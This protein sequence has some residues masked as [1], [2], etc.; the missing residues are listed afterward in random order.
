VLADI[1]TDTFCVDPAHVRRLVTPRTKALLPVHFGGQACRIEEIVAIGD[2]AGIP[3][4]E[5]AAHSF[6]ARV[7]GQQLGR[8]GRATTFSFYAT[9]NLTS[10]E[11]AVHHDAALAHVARAATH[12]ATA[13]RY[14]DGVQGLRVEFRAVQLATCTRRWASLEDR[15]LARK[16]PWRT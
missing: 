15:R 3:V 14:A 13:G 6:G 16:A 5:D 8:F 7:R 11:R 1:E 12:V 10:A 4:V 2:K 9:K